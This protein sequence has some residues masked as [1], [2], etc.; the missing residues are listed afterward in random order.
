MYAFLDWVVQRAALD[1]DAAS[2]AIIVALL[3]L[4]MVATAVVYFPS[5][6]VYNLLRRHRKK[7]GRH[8]V[9][10]KAGRAGEDSGRGKA[11]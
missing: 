4:A 11:A 6:A 7:G 3:M 2:C 1:P 5:V 8:V 9:G 10:E